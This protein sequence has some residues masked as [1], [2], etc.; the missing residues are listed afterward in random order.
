M[1][2]IRV[3]WNMG[4]LKQIRNSGLGLVTEQVSEIAG[5]ANADAGGGFGYES[6]LSGG[7]GRARGTVYTD[8]PRA[9]VVNR[10]D[11]TLIRAMGGSG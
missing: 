1:A 11:N 5:R 3:V 4:A 10:R 2:K 7:A 6:H 8:T 9:M